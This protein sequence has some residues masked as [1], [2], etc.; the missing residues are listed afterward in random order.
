MKRWLYR[1]R[2]V[3]HGTLMLWP[4]WPF[5]DAWRAVADDFD[6]GDSDEFI[7]DGTPPRD[8]VR[9]SLSYWSD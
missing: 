7:S 4:H 1:V 8:A 5:F 3:W 9:E 6:N 2:Y